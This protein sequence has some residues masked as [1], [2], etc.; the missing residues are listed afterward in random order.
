MKDIKLLI[1]L[2]LCTFIVP[3]VVNFLFDP[4]SLGSSL[5]GVGIIII[6]VLYTSYESVAKAGNLFVQGFKI[7]AMFGTASVLGAILVPRLFGSQVRHDLSFFSVTQYIIFLYLAVL[8]MLFL[9]RKFYSK[10]KS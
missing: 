3:E 2:L 1:P 7:A 10:N 8:A 4:E 6:L 9:E 5:E